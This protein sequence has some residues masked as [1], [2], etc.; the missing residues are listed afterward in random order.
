MRRSL[1][2]LFG[3]ASIALTSATPVSAQPAFVNGITIPGSRLDATR[4]PGA[5]G[6]RFGFFSDIYYDP[7]TDEWWA[8]SDRGPGGGLISYGTR[9]QRF[10]IDINPTTGAISHF[11]ILE[12]VKF[13]DPR[14]LLTGTGKALNGL[15][16]L[17]LNGFE[18]TLGRSFDPEGLVIDPRTGNFLVADEYGPSLYAFDR[19]GRLVKVFETPMNVIPRAGGNV[20]YVALRD[21]CGGSVPVPLCGANEGRQDNRGYEGLAVSPDGSRLYAVL[22][23][24]LI[25][26]PGPNDG[27][28]GRNARIIVFDNDRLS[29]TYGESLA[30]YVYKLEL[31][32]DVAARINAVKPGDATS[33][34][35]RQGRNIGVSAIHAINDTQF[36][37]L[38]RDNR[39]IGVDDPAGARAVGSKRVYKIDISGATDVTAISLGADALPA[40]VVPVA[41]SGVFIDISAHSLL[42]NGKQ[43]EKWEGMAIGPELR[44]GRRLILLGNDN[45]YSVTQ[46]GEGEQFDVYVDFAGNFARCVLDDPTKCEINPAS[47]DLV[48]DNPVAVPSNFSLLPGVLHAYRASK[49]DLAGYQEPRKPRGRHD[50][51]DN[52]HHGH[53]DRDDDHDGHG[54]H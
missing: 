16:P 38:E 8:L 41:K 47:G 45:D 54:R 28:T 46:T 3:I 13:T 43:A 35:P 11:R 18:G 34:D 19:K 37:V 53:G 9:V 29:Q 5:N 4:Q 17:D 10:S 1:Y 30:Q 27:R 33:T 14:G 51:D 49:S 32:A 6:G 36:L 2:V 50:D 20:N 40:G 42:P 25:N 12:T 7:S 22:Q 23:D 26:E 39:G 21:A 52:D 24:P 31:Q 44:G 15:N 48:I